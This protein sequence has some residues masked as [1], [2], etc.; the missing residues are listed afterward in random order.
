MTLG[1]LDRGQVRGAPWLDPAAVLVTC[2][3]LLVVAAVAM[4]ATRGVVDLSVAAAFCCLI[5]FGEMVRLRLPDDRMQAPIGLAAALGYGLLSH[6]P[7]AA[8]DAGRAMHSVLQTVLIVAIGMLI[9]ALPHVITG[10]PSELESIARNILVVAAVAAAFRPLVLNDSTNEWLTERR[11][12]YPLLTILAVLLLVW[13]LEAALAA[14][15]R[16]GRTRGPFFA[17]L[18]NELRA[19]LGI[20]SAIAS[21]GV[22]IAL[23]VWEIGLWALPVVSIP[24]LLVQM[25]YRRYAAIS[26]TQIQTI[27]ALS[28][29]TEVGGYTESGHA[30]RVAELALAVG[31]DLGLSESRLR[32]LRYAAL[33]HDLGQLSLQDPI[34]GGATVFQA[35]DERRR[36]AARGA[37]V[38]RQTGVVDEV[39][40]IVEAQAEQYRRPHLGDDVDVPLESRII[41]V[42][43][44]FDDLAGGSAAED[45]QLNALEELRLGMAYEYDP[46]VVASLA[47]IL[48][49]GTSRR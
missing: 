26:R 13:P 37:A 8:A 19:Y 42:V 32:L 2:A 40:Q 43:N 23:A 1:Q 14:G 21:T 38:I 4:A 25:A 34:P 29:T 28:R 44:A 33:M 27:R 6:V 36:I 47:R 46:R 11:W 30:R 5:A 31:Q 35:P 12:A 15:V 3:A 48:E 45:A 22:L 41:K 7:Q 20:G 17:F 49:H 10:R 16:A 39:A 24:L 9:G 18:R